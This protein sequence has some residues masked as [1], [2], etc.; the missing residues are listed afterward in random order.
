MKALIIALAIVMLATISAKADHGLVPFL[1]G[2]VF[3]TILGLHPHY[4][5]Y[6]RQCYWTTQPVWDGYRWRN[7]RVRVCE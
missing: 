6:Y 5:P 7:Q 3:G 4:D 1:G 2:L